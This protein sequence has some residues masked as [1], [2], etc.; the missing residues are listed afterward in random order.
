[1]VREDGTNEDSCFTK[2]K[3]GR[4]GTATWPGQDTT[5]GHAHHAQA[6]Q[7]EQQHKRRVRPVL[8]ERINAEAFE[9]DDCKRH[10]DEKRSKVPQEGRKPVR[11]QSHTRHD[12]VQMG[13]DG[14]QAQ[15]ER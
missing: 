3:G 8:E 2:R 12:L 15:V 5:F 14:R 1:M 6:E 10:R 11:L 7:D 4:P 9:Q 13:C